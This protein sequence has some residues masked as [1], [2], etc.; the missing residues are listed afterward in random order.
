[1]IAAEVGS[2]LLYAI[3]MAFLPQYFGERRFR[4]EAA[5]LLIRRVTDLN[6]VLSYRFIYKVTIIVAISAFPLV[7]V[8]YLK[9]RLSSASYSK[10][11]AF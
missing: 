10:V 9:D 6:F 2:F 8:R 3:S 11:T 1:M 5:V 7:M 4:Q